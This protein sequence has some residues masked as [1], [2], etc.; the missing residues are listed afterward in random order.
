MKKIKKTYIILASVVLLCFVLAGTFQSLYTKS[1]HN[2]PDIHEFQAQ[3][4]KKVVKAQLQLND[5]LDSIKKGKPYFSLTPADKDISYY[6]YKNDS[7]AFWTENELGVPVQYAGL[8]Q[9]TPFLEL[10]HAYCVYQRIRYKDLILAAVIKIKSN[11]DNP[12]SYLVNGF[13]GGFDLNP[14]V[15]I[16]KGSPEDKNAV[17]L[18]PHQYLF[19]LSNSKEAPVYENLFAILSIVCWISGFLLLFIGIG[20]SYLLLGKEKPSLMFL[21]ASAAASAVILSIFIQ[22][23]IPSILFLS[24]IFSPI[25]YASGN[26][27]PSLGHLIILSIFILG[28]VIFFFLHL[29][30]SSF[31]FAGKQAKHIHYLFPV[32]SLL[33]FIAVCLLLKNVIYNS[34]FD[35]TLVESENIS[36]LSLISITLIL[37]WI[38]CFVLIRYKLLQILGEK[39]NLKTALLYNALVAIGILA[40]AW[41]LGLDLFLAPWYFGLCTIIDYLHFRRK[42]FFSMANITVLVLGFTTFIVYYSVKHTHVKMADKYQIM[43]TNIQSSEMLNRNILAEILFEE[44]NEE[45]YDDESLLEISNKK[46]SSSIELQNYLQ[47]TYFR[48]FWSN[49]DI[50][51]YLFQQEHPSKADLEKVQFYNNLIQK[52][53]QVKKTNFYFCTDPKSKIDYLGVFDLHKEVLYIEFYSKLLT[54]SYSYPEP[55]LKS[56][57][58]SNNLSQNVSIANYENGVMHAQRG[59]FIYPTRTNWI[60]K[61]ELKSFSFDYKGY[62][63]FVYNGKGKNTIVVSRQQKENFYLYLTY[64]AYL[65]AFYFLISLLVY[66][67]VSLRNRRKRKGSFSFLYKLQLSFTLLLIISFMAVFLVSL[68]YIINQ[69]KNRQNSEIQNKTRYIQKYIQESFKDCDNLKQVNV[70]DLNFYLQDLSKIYQ[71]DIHIFDNR[72]FLVGTSQPIIFARGLASSYISPVPFFQKQNNYTQTEHI[73]KLNYLSAYTRLYNDKNELIGYMAVPSFLSSDQMHK[74]IFNLVAVIINVYLLIIVVASLLSLFISNQLTKPIKTLEDKLNAINLKGQN[75]RIEYKHQDEIGHLVEQYNKMVDKLE[76]SAKTLAKD[77]RESAWKQMARQVTH[78]INNPLTPMK[79][80]IQHLQRM[81]TIDP[82]AFNEYFKKSSQLLIEQIEHLS[83]IATAFSDFA[84]MP[85]TQI[86][87][88][89]ISDRLEQ[90]IELFKN[91]R[92]HVEITYT[93]TPDQLLVLADKEQLTQVFNNLLKNAIQ[94]IPTN[95]KGY[96][97]IATEVKN[98]HVRVEIKDN[99]TGIE[100][101]IQDK[102]F[103]PNFTTKTSG[104]GLGLAIVKNIVTSNGGKIWFTTT[105]NEGTSFF[106]EFPL[107]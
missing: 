62:T 91:N 96:I 68:N 23:N 63:H 14:Q 12:N 4:E 39:I 89:N 15:R 36:S 32:I 60:P 83:A 3:L 17:F 33:S 107:V 99:G 25:Y 35:I 48:G 6:I 13:T 11:Y 21:F 84:K 97:H 31:K 56:E 37:S 98:K 64:W 43:A 72:G 88:V 73:G 101:D 34:S 78:E 26:F 81:Q 51:F 30:K 90:I 46:D 65:F 57:S 55:L 54:T 5:M 86:E 42:K 92:E 66:G 49:Y 16:I 74:E 1:A 28:E 105:P 71:T 69:S 52:S 95:R 44:V 40:G 61:H 2:D 18:P 85:E 24:D 59:S 106:V 7:L 47:R 8:K 94:A 38:I 50:K 100:T 103:T 67:P 22:I 41:A 102:L 29:D 80:T 93:P 10:R 19:S 45:L 75:E 76:E 79:L 58:K 87:H 9:Q 70:V 20:A 82:E 104:M 27:L 77:E 53:E